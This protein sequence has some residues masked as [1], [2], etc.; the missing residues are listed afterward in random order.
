MTAAELLKDLIPY[1]TE[2]EVFGFSS[3]VL[4]RLKEEGMDT[5]SI[6]KDRVENERVLNKC[7]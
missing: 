6:I 7:L 1:M 3:M 4:L 5:E 2:S